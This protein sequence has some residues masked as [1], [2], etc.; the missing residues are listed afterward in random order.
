MPLDDFFNKIRVIEEFNIATETV[1]I[2]KDNAY[3]IEELLK[4]Q[5]AKGIDGFKQPVTLYGSPFYKDATVWY[6]TFHGEGLGKETGWITNY[7]T[8]TFYRSLFVEVNGT[9]FF[10][11]S[12]VPY[13]DKIVAR[14]GEALMRLTEENLAWFSQNVVIP[15]LQSIFSSRFNGV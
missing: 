13:Y 14:S 7:M 3:F 15:E 12:N 4:E 6:K 8:G 5:L 10:V 9:D 1:R 11:K 2:I